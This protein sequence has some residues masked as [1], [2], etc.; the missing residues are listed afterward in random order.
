MKR[1]HIVISGDVQGVGF[2]AWVLRYVKDKPLTGWVKNREDGAVE[3]VAEGPRSDLEQLIK[4]CQHGPD[5]AWVERVD[6]TWSEWTGE[7]VSFAV[8]Y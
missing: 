7:F 2:R 4:E 6:A 8:V 1:V 5:V 3:I